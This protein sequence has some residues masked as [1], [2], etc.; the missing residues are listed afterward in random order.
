VTRRLAPSPR[1]FAVLQPAHTVTLGVDSLAVAELSS[2]VAIGDTAVPVVSVDGFQV[3]GVVRL[4]PGYP[5]QEDHRIRAISHT[6]L[7]LASSGLEFVHTR[8]E[9]VELLAI[10]PDCPN[11]CSSIASCVERVCACPEGYMGEDCSVARTRCDDDC[12][13]H[14]L[15]IAGLCSCHAG[16]TGGACQIAAQLCPFNCSGCAHAARPPAPP[17][18]APRAC[19]CACACTPHRRRARSRGHALS[20][21]S[22]VR[23]SLTLAA[24]PSSM[25]SR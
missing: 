19:A 16:F 15:C 7:W 23:S 12:S 14:G 17:A 24:P 8:R 20:C 18:P 2:D 9:A 22:R 13:G 1:A 5:N 25:H 4:H 3:G 10:V 6:S 11:N 21:R